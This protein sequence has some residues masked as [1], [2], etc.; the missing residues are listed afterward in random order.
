MS[1]S[2][3]K[4]QFKTLIQTL[5]KNTNF[6]ENIEQQ[7]KQL[8][9]ESNH[10]IVNVMPVTTVIGLQNKTNINGGGQQM[11]KTQLTRNCSIIIQA[12]EL[13]LKEKA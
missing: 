13:Q 7:K 10:K 3:K 9:I 11:E 5:R 8:D 4:S 2:N 1:T 12:A 6:N